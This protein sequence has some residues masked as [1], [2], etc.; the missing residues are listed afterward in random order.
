[1]PAFLLHIFFYFIFMVVMEGGLARNK[2]IFKVMEV[3][4]GA[5]E[6]IQSMKTSAAARA[7]SRCADLLH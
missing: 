3:D 4:P 2:E 1:M 6:G 5:M 7:F